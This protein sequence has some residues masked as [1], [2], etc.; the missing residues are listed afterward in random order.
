MAEDTRVQGRDRCDSCGALAPRL[1]IGWLFVL[2]VAAV[3][4]PVI[5][6]AKES[7]L[8]ALKALFEKRSY[9]YWIDLISWC[10][11]GAVLSWWLALVRNVVRRS[12]VIKETIGVLCIA[13]VIVA[14]GWIYAKGITFLAASGI[15]NKSLVLLWSSCITGVAWCATIHCAGHS[16]CSSIVYKRPGGGIAAHFVVRE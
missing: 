7:H 6:A 1:R 2:I 16:M 10:E 4:F 9:A 11:V 3:T 8:L 5:V 12:A 15:E 14:S 13:C